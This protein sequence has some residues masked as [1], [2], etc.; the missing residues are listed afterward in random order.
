M[1]LNYDVG[2]FTI[3]NNADNTILSSSDLQKMNA[4]IDLHMNAATVVKSDDTS[5]RDK[6]ITANH[7]RSSASCGLL[8]SFNTH[9]HT[10]STHACTHT[11]ISDINKEQDYTECNFRIT[12]KI[13]MS[14]QICQAHSVSL[15]FSS[16][17]FHFQ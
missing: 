5:E 2:D 15:Q 3:L 12:L 1:S 4:S 10:H 13:S 14:F 7:I 8:T 6:K 16:A 11:Q 17:I 9:T